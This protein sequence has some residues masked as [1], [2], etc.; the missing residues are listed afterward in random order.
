MRPQLRSEPAQQDQQIRMIADPR[1]HPEWTTGRVITRLGFFPT[2][3]LLLPRPLGHVSATWGQGL[4]SQF[5][6]YIIEFRHTQ[7]SLGEQAN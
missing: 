6:S 4:L 1:S 5:L 3:A 2:R 7:F